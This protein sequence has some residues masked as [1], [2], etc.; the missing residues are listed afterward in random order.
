MNR[1][2]ALIMLLALAAL[3]AG[4]GSSV[5][6]TNSDVIAIDQRGFRLGQLVWNWQAHNRAVT[7]TDFIGAF[8]HESTCVLGKSRAESHV[9]WQSRRGPGG[10]PTLGGFSPPRDNSSPARAQV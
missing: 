8:G 2:L 6:G 3:W 4:S 10:F 7:L 1:R 5:A 9:A